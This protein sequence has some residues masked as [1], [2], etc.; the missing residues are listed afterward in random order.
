MTDLKQTLL[1]IG[2]Q[3]STIH[4]QQAEIVKLMKGFEIK[5]E[6]HCTVNRNIPG[7]RK[8][9]VPFLEKPVSGRWYRKF[10]SYERNGV[11][12]WGL[13]ANWVRIVFPIVPLFLFVYTIGPCL[14]GTQYIQQ[15]CNYQWESVYP[16]FNGVRMPNMFSTITRIA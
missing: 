2:P 8:K 16:K 12:N 1:K 6:C 15:N 3:H 5:A 11:L 10:H 14:N 9:N 7:L 13:S 4:E